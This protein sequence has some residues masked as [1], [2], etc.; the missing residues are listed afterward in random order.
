MSILIFLRLNEM[1]MKYH[2]PEADQTWM[3]DPV[4]IIVVSNNIEEI[5]SV[6]WAGA[7]VIFFPGVHLRS[8][9]YRLY[10]YKVA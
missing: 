3:K 10:K 9:A 4:E 5:E 2:K 7:S 6:L 1:Y 8:P